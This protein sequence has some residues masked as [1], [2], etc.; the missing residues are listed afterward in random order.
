MSIRN[1]DHC[2]CGHNRKNHDDSD[3][4]CNK[5]SCEVFHRGMRE[6]TLLENQVAN[7]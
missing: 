3:G 4:E 2:T 7:Q 1:L 5:C 6:M